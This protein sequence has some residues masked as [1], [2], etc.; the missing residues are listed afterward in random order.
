MAFKIIATCDYVIAVHRTYMPDRRR[1]A[2]TTR[3]STTSCGVSKTENSP[4]TGT[5]KEFPRRYRSSCV[6]R[7][8]RSTLNDKPN[9]GGI[10][11]IHAQ[12]LAVPL[13]YLPAYRSWN[14]DGTL[15]VYGTNGILTQPLSTPKD[16]FVTQE[17]RL[18]SNPDSTLMHRIGSAGQSE[19]HLGSGHEHFL[20][21][22]RPQCGRPSVH[23]QN[24]LWLRCLSAGSE[25]SAYLWCGAER[26]F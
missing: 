16:D 6:C 12:E 11:C 21:R 24:H 2:I 22:L 7:Y 1:T 15:L 20:D 19:R 14:N 25:R 8:G 26:N 9:P 4:S 5:V 3:H 10:K 23:H 13:T 18:A 17:L